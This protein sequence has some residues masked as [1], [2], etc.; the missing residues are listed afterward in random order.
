MQQGPHAAASER[1]PLRPELAS[2]QQL[3]SRAPCGPGNPCRR[4]GPA[5]AAVH[6]GAIRAAIATGLRRPRCNPQS[7]RGAAAGPAAGKMCCSSAGRA[8]GG[9]SRAVQGPARL[10]ACQS[11]QS[12]HAAAPRGATGRWQRSHKGEPGMR[13]PSPGMPR[14]IARRA[15]RAPARRLGPCGEAAARPAP[16]APG[17]IRANPSRRPAPDWDAETILD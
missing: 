4:R 8:G 11:R 2:S 13:R 6:S 14:G 9:L 1:P 12:I 17:G 7:R 5:R 15:A 10:G 16:D 3:P